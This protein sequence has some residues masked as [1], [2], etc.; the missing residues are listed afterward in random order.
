MATLEGSASISLKALLADNTMP[1][2]DSLI[3]RGEGGSV[4]C[5]ACGHRCVVKPGRPGVCRVRFN[6]DGA[7]R[8]PA[9]YVA[10]V[11]VDP[12]EK[13]PFFH[14]NPARNA[15]SFGKI[16]LHR[17]P[18]VLLDPT[19]FFEGLLAQIERGVKEDFDS[20]KV[21]GLFQISRDPMDAVDRLEAAD[22]P[23]AA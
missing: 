5:L 22:P 19:G 8:V 14:A 1:A 4:R 2:A 9:R 12:I 17:R 3:I 11:Q 20:G 10:G 16:G 7:L 15:L 21:N 18:I 13:K 6:V 23:R